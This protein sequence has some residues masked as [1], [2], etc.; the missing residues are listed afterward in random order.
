MLKLQGTIHKCR[1]TK[2]GNFDSLH[3]ALVPDNGMPNPLFVWRYLSV[4]LYSAECWPLIGIEIGQILLKLDFSKEIQL[5]NISQTH[6][7]R[8]P[9]FFIK[10]TRFCIFIRIRIFLD[11][12]N[13]FSFL[14]HI[15]FILKNKEINTSFCK[16]V[17]C[18]FISTGK[19]TQG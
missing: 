12:L 2:V 9:P 5:E 6:I 16:H 11:L 3:L 17:R 1:H 7:M 4:Y 8:P 13:H 19:N 10:K 14:C 15:V 18:L